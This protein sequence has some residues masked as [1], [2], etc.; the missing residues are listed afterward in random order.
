MK[1]EWKVVIL[2]IACSLGFMLMFTYGCS[3]GQKTLY[4]YQVGIYKEEENK[5]QKLEELEKMG[6]VGYTY[7][8]DDQYYVLSMISDQKSEV[9]KHAAQVK[10]IMKTYVVSSQTTTDMLLEDLSQGKTYD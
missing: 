9:E 3:I 6:I 1:F 4:A 8:K 10:G 5:N 7:Q 2:G